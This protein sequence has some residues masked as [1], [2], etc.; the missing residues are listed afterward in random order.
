MMKKKIRRDPQYLYYNRF[1]L[2]I[3]LA[4]D[5]IYPNFSAFETI[6][7]KYNTDFMSQNRL[8]KFAEFTGMYKNIDF[9]FGFG[10]MLSNDSDNDSLNIKFNS[11]LFS[12]NFGYQLLNTNK[13]RIASRM[14]LKWQ[15]FRLLK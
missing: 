11:A 3:S 12:L 4:L 14:S 6:L 10:Y 9:G 2:R 1:A 7:G 5:I 15:R 8:S 13:F